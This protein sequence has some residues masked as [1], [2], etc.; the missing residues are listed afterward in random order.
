ME[1]SSERLRLI[2]LSRDQLSLLSST[3]ARLGAMLNIHITPA[4]L[5]ENSRRAVDRKLQKM[6]AA[7]VGQHPWFT[8][9]LIVIKDAHAGAGLVGFKGSPNDSGE[10]EIGYGIDPAFRRSGFTHEAVRLLIDWAF[11]HPECRAITATHVLPTNFASQ[12]LLQKAGFRL[13]ESTLAGLSY[14]LEK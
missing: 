12:R 1:I 2:A 14:R 8:Y 4:I 5:D 10:V 6:S 11:T 9:W 13:I 3:P 7:P